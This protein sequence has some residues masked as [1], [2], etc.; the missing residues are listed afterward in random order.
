MPIIQQTKTLPASEVKNNFGAIASQV[1]NG[2]YNE[3]IVENRGE[4]IVAIIKVEELEA[5]KDFREQERR[6]DALTRLRNLRDQVQAKVKGKL[7]EEEVE[8]I[9][10]R[11]SR[12]LI[13]DLEKEGKIRFERKSS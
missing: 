10:N 2:E 5:L 8:N 7:S 6:K 12:E 13:E 3:V 9:S 11:F 1:K 4:P